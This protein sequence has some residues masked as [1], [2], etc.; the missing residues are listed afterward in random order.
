VRRALPASIFDDQGDAV[1]CL[2]MFDP[3]PPLSELAATAVDVARERAVESRR[4]DALFDDELAVAVDAAFPDPE[5]GTLSER[6]PVMAGY[7]A[8]RTRVLDDAAL[9]AVRSGCG[10]LVVLASGLDARGERLPW[11]RELTVFELDLAEMVEFRAG[12]EHSTGSASGVERRVIACDLRSDWSE[13]L[14]AAGFDPLAPSVWLAEGMLM[15]LSASENDALLRTITGL[16][17]PGSRVL[18]EHVPSSGTR[19]QDDESGHDLGEEGS[20]WRS[21]QDDPVA[22]LGE[23]GWTAAPIDVAGAV[24]SWGRAL[25][26][27]LDP[28][29]V[30][31]ACAQLI[32]ARN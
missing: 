16:S 29:A 28:A 5:S 9:D 19:R 4:P 2:S 27:V 24:T 13:P 23:H 20:A 10:Q 12:L 7:I 14:L 22:W 1:P 15:Y 17:A 3:R 11:D 31:P 6:V 21:T 26:S 8:T 32:S 25:P 30:G 18:L